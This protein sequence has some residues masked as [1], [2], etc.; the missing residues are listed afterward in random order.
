VKFS[1]PNRRK[2]RELRFVH[3]KTWTG[4]R[5]VPAC[6]PTGT[7]KVSRHGQL[8][9]FH[10]KVTCGSC[11]ERL[12]TANMWPEILGDEEARRMGW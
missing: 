11:I 7:E 1:K 6:D 3:Y 9:P 10:D 2:L 8:T 5:A 4:D 12:K